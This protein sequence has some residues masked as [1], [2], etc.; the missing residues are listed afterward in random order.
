MSQSA[1]ALPLRPNRWAALALVVAAQFMVVLDISIV[2]VALATIKSDLHFSEASLQWVVSAYA[3]VFGGF[4]LLGGRLADLIGRRRVFIAGVAL[5][6]I[7]SAL[8]GLA[9]SAGSLVAFRGIE[10]LGG[11]LFAPAGL[12]LLMTTFREGR[13]RNLALGIWGAASGSGA[14]VAALLGALFVYVE[15]RAEAPLLPFRI[16]RGNTLATANVITAIIASIAFSQ[17]FLLTLYLQQVLPYSAA[18]SGLA[19]AAIA[20]TVAVM[21]NVAQRLVTRFGPR[22]ILAAGLLFA[23]GSEA[24][25]S[26]LPVQGHYVPDLLP[27]FLLIGFGIGVGFVAVTIAGLQGVSPADAGIASGLVNAS[28]QVGGAIGL[29]VVSTVATSYA[30]HISTGVAGAAALTH[31]F[32]VSFAVLALLALA[33]AVLTG[34]FLRSQRPRPAAAEP[35]PALAELEEAA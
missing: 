26:R 29:A 22:R 19:F 13:D 20:G 27:A 31:G 34:A 11:A 4:L 35:V 8:C 16:F 18:K 15:L 3:I 5:F 14:A 7:S 23:A 9:W 1:I 10:G 25:L 32:R 17:F 21:S 33:G 2:N 24:W 12:S 30:G 6:T 28:R